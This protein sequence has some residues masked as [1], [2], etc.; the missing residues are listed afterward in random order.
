MG[1]LSES[2]TG[3]VEISRPISL[4]IPNDAVVHL[5]I[6]PQEHP[7]DEPNG[8]MGNGRGRL[9]DIVETTRK[10]AGKKQEPHA[11]RGRRGK[12]DEAEGS[13]RS[14]AASDAAHGRQT[15]S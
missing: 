10:L 6:G 2:R 4:D 5:W 13:E 14:L 11:R 3:S 1:V 7:E 12:R 8:D 15:E 9:K